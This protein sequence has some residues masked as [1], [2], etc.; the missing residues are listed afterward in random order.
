M[1]IAIAG[2]GLLGR[3]MAWRLLRAGH[4]VSLF[5][6]DSAAGEHCAGRVA[7][8][9]LAPYSELVHCEREIFDWGLLAMS[10]WPQLL[11]ELEA[12]TGVAVDYQRRGSV[13]VAHSADQSHL[14]HF[15]R[16][17]RLRLPQDCEPVEWLD[18]QG[19]A[20]LEPELAERFSTATF[21]RDE[22]CLDNWALLDQLGAA[23]R[24]RGGQWLSGVEVSA[25]APGQLSLDG[26]HQSFEWVIDCRGVGA[27]DRLADL[28]GVRGEVL[29]VQASEVALSRPVRL[30]HPRYQLYIAPK[31]NHVY[32]IGATEIESDSMAPIT[33]RSSLELQSALYSVHKGFAEASVIRAYANCRPAFLNNL[34]RIEI[35]PGLMSVNGL[36]RHGYL[37]SP[38]VMD[39]AIDALAG[40]LSHPIVT[41]LNQSVRSVASQ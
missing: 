7:A 32:V 18:R 3:L 20:A 30:M 40:R 8:A 9:M 4:T 22:G 27:R 14:D 6:R 36:Y 35:E 24:A 17:L 37:L 2:A 19:L 28:R 25:V 34:P 33:V 10:R 31:P 21:L 12:D 41:T 13:V 26:Q 5:D 23:I 11:A 15:N 39:A 1:K 29:W 38:W 16:H